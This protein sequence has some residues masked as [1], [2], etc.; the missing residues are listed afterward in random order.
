MCDRYAGISSSE[1]VGNGEHGPHLYSVIC[2]SSLQ[3][4]QTRRCLYPDII[5]G[6]EYDHLLMSRVRESI[7]LLT[8]EISNSII[9]TAYNIYNR[10]SYRLHLHSLKNRPIIGL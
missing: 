7:H 6:V 2:L 5:L 4:I 1:A 9:S 10:V 8:R 3:T